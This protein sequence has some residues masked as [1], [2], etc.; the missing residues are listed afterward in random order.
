MEAGSSSM[1]LLVRIPRNNYGLGGLGRLWKSGPV[2]QELQINKGFERKMVGLGRLARLWKF[3][4][5]GRALQ[6]DA[7][8][9]T[10]KENVRFGEPG[11]M[12]EICVS[13]ARS[14]RLILSA[15]DLEGTW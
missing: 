15:K 3:S 2:G 4:P 6:I 11:Q 9:R 7:L 8:V 14:S 13:G 5:E 1:M 10:P 12:I